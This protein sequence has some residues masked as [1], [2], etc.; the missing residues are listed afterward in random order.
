[1]NTEIKTSL[2]N[3]IADADGDLNA[4]LEALED[5]HYLATLDLTQNQVEEVYL[6]IKEKIEKESE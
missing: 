4:A 2:A 6:T 5:G 1:M 3:I